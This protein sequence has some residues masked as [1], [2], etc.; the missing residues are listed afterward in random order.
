MTLKHIY[1]NLYQDEKG[2]YFFGMEDDTIPVVE[3]QSYLLIY[4]LEF[5]KEMREENRGL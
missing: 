2:K 3:Q 1:K 4:I 5:L